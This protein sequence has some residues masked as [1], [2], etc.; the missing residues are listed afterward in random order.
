MIN[1][2]LKRGSIARELRSR[3][4]APQE[5]AGPGPAAGS[6]KLLWVSA[7][8]VVMASANLAASTLKF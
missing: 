2:S 8:E 4:Y 6:R 3:G 1:A 7:T 5:S